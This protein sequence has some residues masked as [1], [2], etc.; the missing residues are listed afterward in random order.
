[1]FSVPSVSFLYELSDALQL[2][3]A[4]TIIIII[5]P[6]V[7][8]WKLRLQQITSQRLHANVT[9]WQGLYIHKGSLILVS[10]TPYQ[11][12]R[13]IKAAGYKVES[14]YGVSSKGSLFSFLSNKSPNVSNLA[15]IYKRKS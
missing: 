14:T 1:M 10:A 2:H 5:L 15:S 4:G 7:Y 3:E 13:K 11:T 6:S 12:Q 8:T 9:R